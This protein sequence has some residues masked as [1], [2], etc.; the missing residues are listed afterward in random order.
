MSQEAVSSGS[1]RE[2]ISVDQIEALADINGLTKRE[3][4]VLC[5]I[6]QK[7]SL[8]AMAEEMCL[9]VNTVKTHVAHVYQKIGVHSRD[10]IILR[11]ER[12]TEDGQL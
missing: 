6:I 12:L 11:I 5:L 8:R 9:S 1:A 2:E 4:D 7:K 10:Q 3:L